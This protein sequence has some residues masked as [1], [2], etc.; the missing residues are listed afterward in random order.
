MF[1]I[2]LIILSS[3]T[4]LI[5]GFFV[6]GKN[7]KN[8]LNIYFFIFSLITGSWIASNL[9]IPYS[10]LGNFWLKTA[11]ALGLLVAPSA[12][13]WILYLIYGERF[14]KIKL[15]LLLIPTPILF[16]LLYINDLFIKRVDEVVIGGFTGEFGILFP[17]YIAYVLI[18]LIIMIG[19]LVRGYRH[20]QGIKSIQ[21]AYVIAGVAGFGCS[22]VL[23]S[24]ILPLFSI[25]RFMPLDGPSTLIFIA[26]FT[27][28][29]VRHRLLDIV[30]IIRKV[31]I[32]G[33]LLMIILGIFSMVAFGLPFVFADSLP[34]DTFQITLVAVAFIVALF[35]QPLRRSI[36]E[37]TDRWFFKGAYKPQQV[38]DE[39]SEKIST[40]IDLRVLL[41][42][43]AQILLRA[44][45]SEHAVFSVR[46]RI[47]R[48]TE[49]AEHAEQKFVAYNT[50]GRHRPM[51]EFT[52]DGKNPFVRFFNKYTGEVII[53]D[54][55]Q[56]DL[57]DI[58]QIKR[59]SDTQIRRRYEKGKGESADIHLKQMV[60]KEMANHEFAIIF[61]VFSKEE[62]VG[63]F[64]LG[65]K[66]SGDIYAHQ[67]LQILDLFSHQV[68][69]AVENAKL[70]ADLKLF[71]EKLQL[72]V[73]KATQDLRVTNSQLTFRNKDL[74]ALQKITNL[75]TRTLDLAQITQ[76]IADS[77]QSELAYV[78]GI[79][80]QK[81]K[82]R[83]TSL[84]I[85]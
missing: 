6:I 71:N 30:V 62:L 7:S 37:F 48:S 26:F 8:K 1:E 67:D 84:F 21:I 25:Q 80:L 51:E 56:K 13:I 18:V 2:G 10:L 75:I 41:D 5:L 50:E 4:S 36:E 77:I 78:G 49:S 74:G 73:E 68:G 39:L 52:Y 82:T 70:Y 34:E 24:F 11:Y 72:E 65:A 16:S 64:G 76:T 85:Y 66:K 79:I 29:I 81:N 33:I 44:F 40:I 12:L 35:F 19:V 63:I 59:R 17:Y 20:A 31:T 27:Y 32:L 23:V 14:S 58:T 15:A 43:T 47:G 54:E 69:I 22:A 61:P 28:A 46:E 55:L 53:R 38:I 83:R 42:A 45:R 60:L 57:E 3:S 9:F